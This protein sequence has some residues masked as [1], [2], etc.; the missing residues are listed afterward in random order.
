MKQIQYFSNIGLMT[1]P[2][3]N[4]IKKLNLV[5]GIF[6]LPIKQR[7]LQQDKEQAWQTEI[8]SDAH[9]VNESPT[10]PM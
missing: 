9:E 5:S 4:L 3:P 1:N 7:P 6:W 2:V 8:W 10:A